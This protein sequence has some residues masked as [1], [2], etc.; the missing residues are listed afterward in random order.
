MTSQILEV[1]VSGGVCRLTLNRPDKRNALNGD[2]VSALSDALDDVS[3]DDAV[4]VIAI[5]GAGK[6]FCAGGD[7]AE[8]AQMV[9]QG[10]EANVTDAMTLGNLF[11]ICGV[12]PS[13]SWPWFGD[14]R[15]R[16]AAGWPPRATWCWPTMTPSSG[17]PRSI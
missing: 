16:A 4:R 11:I 15:W 9:D 3:E 14:G 7:L 1:G 12:I 5:T 6:D 13:P 2:L 17:I 10:H 8:L